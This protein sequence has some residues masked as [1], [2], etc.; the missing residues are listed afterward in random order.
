MELDLYAADVSQTHLSNWVKGITSDAQAVGIQVTHS[1]VTASAEVLKTGLSLVVNELCGLPEVRVSFQSADEATLRTFAYKHYHSRF[2]QGWN[3][4]LY[5]PA[6]DAIFL[7]FDETVLARKAAHFH[8]RE[9]TSD[10][11]YHLY[12]TQALNIGFYTVISR[13]GRRTRSLQ[14]TEKAFDYRLEGAEQEWARLY[15]DKIQKGY[16]VGRPAI[17]EQFELELPL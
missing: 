11:V 6:K 2:D 1:P 16:T 14:Q 9:G 3:V 17:S 7:H 13:Y 10:K 15:H 12:L 4:C 8:Y 5:L